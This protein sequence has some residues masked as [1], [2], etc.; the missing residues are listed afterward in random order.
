MFIHFVY[1]RSHSR[2]RNQRQLSGSSNENKQGSSTL[3]SVSRRF[4]V[5]Q[6]SRETFTR[7]RTPPFS[8]SF[9]HPPLAP[10]APALLLACPVFLAFLANLCQSATCSFF[11]G[12]AQFNSSVWCTGDYFTFP[13][14]DPSRLLLTFDKSN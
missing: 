13:S 12:R 14:C 8:L 1:D 6:L 11:V 10:A 4:K 9:V 3:F 5:G 7:F 2:E